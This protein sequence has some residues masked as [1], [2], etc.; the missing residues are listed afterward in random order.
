MRIIAQQKKMLSSSSE[1]LSLSRTVRQAGSEVDG[2]ERNLR[3]LSGLDGCRYELRQQREVIE[4]LTGKIVNLSTSLYEISETY[5]SAEERNE[6]NLEEIPV[7]RGGTIKG[8]LYA[9]TEVSKKVQKI[10]GR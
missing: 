4:L 8:S 3:G 5:L 10:L 2:I 1:L 7:L 9:G 6:Y